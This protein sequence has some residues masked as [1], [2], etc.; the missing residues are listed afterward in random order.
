MFRCCHEK[1][2]KK[3]KKKNHQLGYDIWLYVCFGE[4]VS[5]ADY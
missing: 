1:K 5:F 3:K 4:M 2:K